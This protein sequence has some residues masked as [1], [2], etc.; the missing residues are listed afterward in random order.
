MNPVN[1]SKPTE[2]LVEEAESN[3]TRLDEIEAMIQARA[4]YRREDI[5]I[6]GRIATGGNDGGGLKLIQG[7]I[8]PGDMPGDMPARDCNDADAAGHDDTGDGE[9]TISGIDA[10]TFVA[11]LASPGERR[12]RR[13]RKL[14]S[15]S[16]SPTACWPSAPPSSRANSPAT[17]KRRSISC[18]SSSP[19]AIYSNKLGPPP[20]P[21]GVNSQPDGHR[22]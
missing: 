5:A 10:P 2:E 19:R 7:L 1:L 8:R 12:P 15:A 20:W 17:S 21:S 13:A 6:A 3:E 22:L 9:N 11:L 14:A 4:V 16:A 18:C